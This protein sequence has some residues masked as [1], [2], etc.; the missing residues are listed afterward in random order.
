VVRNSVPICESTFAR[1][2]IARPEPIGQALREGVI[3]G[4][5]AQRTRWT[6]G[7]VAAGIALTL[8]ATTPARAD[9]AAPAQTSS[10]L[11]P[12]PAPGTYRLIRIGPQFLLKEDD[13]GQVTEVNEPPAR[14]RREQSAVAAAVMMGIITA[15][16]ALFF[17]Q[18]SE[19]TPPL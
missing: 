10:R 5:V 16:A 4:K 14:P 15:G 18:R 8:A 19:L 17:R 1:A 6:R 2:Q 11:L 9:V 12:L 3:M 7:F 13:Q